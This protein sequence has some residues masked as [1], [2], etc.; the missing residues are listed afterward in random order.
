M[1]MDNSNELLSTSFVGLSTIWSCRCAKSFLKPLFK[2]SFECPL[3]SW[4]VLDNL[5]ICWIKALSKGF[6]ICWY[7]PRR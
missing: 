7:S 3:F 2:L 5:I 6:L 1:N 4:L